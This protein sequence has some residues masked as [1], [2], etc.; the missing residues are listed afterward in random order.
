MVSVMYVMYGDEDGLASENEN[1]D[2][3]LCVSKHSILNLIQ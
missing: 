2:M 3:H 1:I